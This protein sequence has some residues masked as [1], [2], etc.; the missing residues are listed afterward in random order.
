MSTGRPGDDGI[1]RRREQLVAPPGSPSREEDWGDANHA[2]TEKLR[3]KNLERLAS[4]Q[5]LD[6]RHS[7]YGYALVDSTHQRIEDRSDMTLDEIESCLE[8][9]A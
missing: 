7:A 3:R 4:T 5:G 8:R 9:R 1:P 2:K 6:L